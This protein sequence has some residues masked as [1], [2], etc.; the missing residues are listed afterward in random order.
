MYVKNLIPKHPFGANGL[1]V[2]EMRNLK[3]IVALFGPNGSGK[4][5][6]LRDLPSQIHRMVDEVR[7][8]DMELHNLVIHPNNE[9]T[10]EVKR[11]DLLAK[12]SQL[13]ENIHIDDKSNDGPVVISPRGNSISDHSSMNET[14]FRNAS[15]QLIANPDFS[16]VKKNCAK[17]I[18]AL[19]KADISKEYHQHVPGKMHYLSHEQI[20]NTNAGLFALLKETIQLTMNKELE[21][22]VDEFLTPIVTLNQRPLSTYELSDGEK[23]LL[24]YCVFLV[25]QSQDKILNENLSL[26]NKVLILDEIE[27]FL[28]PKS[29]IDLIAGLRRLVGEQ[30]QIWIASHSLAIL[31]IL[32]REEIWLMDQGDVKCPSIETPN[33]VISALIGENNIDGLEN[34]LSSQHQWASIQFALE[35]LFPPGVINHKKD[36]AQQQQVISQLIATSEPFYLLDFGAGKGRIA[37]E[38]LR[39]PGLINKLYYQALETNEELYS[40]LQTLTKKL[41]DS[42]AVNPQEDREVL[43]TSDKLNEAK[44]QKFFDCVLMI[45]VLHEI[46]LNK[47]NSTLNAL[48]G[49]LKESG[50]LLILEDQA[51]PR[52]ENAHEYGF[53]ILDKEEIQ[54]LFSRNNTL[55]VHPHA[56]PKYADRLTCIEVPKVGSSV[57]VGSIRAALHR[58]KT[59]C[60][61]AINHLRNKSVKTAKD[62]RKNG[63]LTQLYANVDM[64]LQDLS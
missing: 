54:L 16:E 51:L 12:R 8:I 30:G 59:N 42:S 19:C 28:H 7:T 26:K 23:E 56:E 60:K 10:V 21:Y 1:V 13:L 47:W 43:N 29:Q 2:R 62:G 3:Q 35:S 5:R 61:T 24:A 22:S 39:N 52:G 44:Y 4:S 41:Q 37:Q 34:I 48:L 55:K 11:Q 46:P 9:E 36:D 53:L 18:K 50:K 32:D 20:Q 45:N 14:E 57:T 64:A 38:L 17:F 15:L 6:M 33:K 58:K 27:L 25:L 63:F 40:E 49:C 31:S